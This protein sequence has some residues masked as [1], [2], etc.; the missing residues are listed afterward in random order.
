MIRNKNI[1]QHISK[2]PL[3]KGG[4]FQEVLLEL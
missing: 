4:L 1:K 2:N 3:D